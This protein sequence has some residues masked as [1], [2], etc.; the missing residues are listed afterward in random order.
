MFDNILICIAYHHATDGNYDNLCKVISNIQTHYKCKYDLVVHT[1]NEE[2]KQQI[3]NKFQNINI[4]VCNNLEHPYFLTWQHRS[5]M[6]DKIDQYDAFIYVE[7]DIV[8]KYEQL[9]NHLKNLND[10]WPNYVPVLVRYE[11]NKHNERYSVDSIEPFKLRSENIIQNN[12]VFYCNVGMYYSGCW[13]LTKPI[14]KELI[15]QGLE[16][17]TTKREK[18]REVAASLVNWELNKQGVVQIEKQ[19]D[20]FQISEH[21]LIHHT[22]NKYVNQPYGMFGRIKIVDVLQ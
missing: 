2:G 4:I 13:S 22:S 17:L 1:N 12:N 15:N 3:L 6:I 20:K 16:F 21:S 18:S 11:F 19:A 5:Y 8:I 9:I 14:L 10:L 7:D